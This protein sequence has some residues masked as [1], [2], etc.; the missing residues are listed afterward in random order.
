MMGIN[1][2]GMMQLIECF[3]TELDG[4]GVTSPGFAA[5]RSPCCSVHT[6]V[7]ALAKLQRDQPLDVCGIHQSTCQVSMVGI[8]SCIDHDCFVEVVES[9]RILPGAAH[10]ASAGGLDVAERKPIVGGFESSFRVVQKAQS[11][12]GTAKLKVNPALL[13]LNESSELRFV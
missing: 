10:D 7:D 6:R 11:F 12:T 5:R 3:A 1:L 13:D 4:T 2:A 9:L 8:P